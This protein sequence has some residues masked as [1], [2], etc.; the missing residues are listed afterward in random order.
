MYR[1]PWER[2]KSLPWRSLFLTALVTTVIVQ[3]IDFITL[4]G[5]ATPGVG[6]SLVTLLSSPLSILLTLAATVGIGALAVL[7]LE[8]TD[9]ASINSGSLWALLLCLIITFLLRMLLPLPALFAPASYIQFVGVMLGIFWKGRPYWQS[10][11]RW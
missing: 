2:F 1:S 11:Q 7:I 10:F 5:V 3:A 4:L 9:P 6:Q 8:R